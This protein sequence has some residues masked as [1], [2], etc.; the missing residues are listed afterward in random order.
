MQHRSKVGCDRYLLR[1]LDRQLPLWLGHLPPK[2]LQIGL[3]RQ[4]VR[5]LAQRQREPAIRRRQIARCAQSRRIKRSHLDHGFR[6]RFIGGRFQN[7]QPVIAILRCA[8]SIQIALRLGDGIARS[9]RLCD[10][11]WLGRGWLASRPRLVDF[12]WL[13]GRSNRRCCGRSFVVWRIIV[14]RISRR[15]RFACSTGSVRLRGR[16]VRRAHPERNFAR[17]VR[18]EVAT[19]R[20]QQHRAF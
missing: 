7:A 2:L 15:I 3:H 20:L 4:I 9:H 17:L 1:E 14:V 13:R 11:R 8:T 6:V 19:H 10:R 18:S 5:I 12:V 16:R